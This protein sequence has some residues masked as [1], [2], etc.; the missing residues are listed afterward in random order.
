MGGAGWTVTGRGFV[1]Q[2]L[3]PVVHVPG[4]TVSSHPDGIFLAL[5]PEADGAEVRRGGLP[6]PRWPDGNTC[7][8]SRSLGFS[9]WETSVLQL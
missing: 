4:K 8:S 3:L 1:L 5:L 9:H 6:R 7:L 2:G